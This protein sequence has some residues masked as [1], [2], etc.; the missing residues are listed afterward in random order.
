MDFAVPSDNKKRKQTI[1]KNWNK[2][3]GEIPEPCS[4]VQEIMEH[5]VISHINHRGKDSGWSWD[6][7]KLL[8]LSQPQYFEDQPGNFPWFWFNGKPL[9]NVKN[10]WKVTSKDL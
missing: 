10:S 8:I 3:T 4:E 6:K 1:F 5:D 2:K 7:Q 9:A